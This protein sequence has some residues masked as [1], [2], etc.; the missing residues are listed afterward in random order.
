[1]PPPESSESPTNSALRAGFVPELGLAGRAIE[2]LVGRERPV[3]GIAM[4]GLPW[5]LHVAQR[6]LLAPVLHG[7]V[8]AKNGRKTGYS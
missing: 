8:P 3:P 4:V 1:M 2:P 7:V 6:A 5:G